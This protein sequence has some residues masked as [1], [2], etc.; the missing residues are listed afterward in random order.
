MPI[1]R[2]PAGVA[3]FGVPVIGSGNVIPVST[4]SYYFVSSTKG[5]SNNDGLS[6]DTP[7]LTVASAISKTVASNGDVIVMMPFHRESLSA[8][9][10][11]TPLAGTSIVGLGWG[12]SRPLIKTTAT[13]ATIACSAANLYFANFITQAGITETA[14]IF[15]VSAADCVINAVDYVEDTTNNYTCISW[16]I[17][18]AAAVRM[19]ITNCKHTGTTAPTGT[20]GWIQIVGGDSIS[21]TNNQILVPR[22]A[23]ATSFVLGGLTT[24]STYLTIQGNILG[25]LS[26]QATVVGVSLFAGS[27]GLVADNRLGNLGKT[28]LAGSFAIANCMGFNNLAAHTVT[29]SGLLDPVVD[30]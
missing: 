6:P 9:G 13:T 19:I 18:T 28:A 24:A 23:A 12:S 25:S 20:T 4:G 26:S 1:S 21:I 15:A 5:S 2:F 29:K 22:A 16:C 7:L 30:S 3:S 8:A 11:W 14:N 10:T 27:T 17:S